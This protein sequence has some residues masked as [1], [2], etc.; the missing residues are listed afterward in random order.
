[1]RL[2]HTVLPEYMYLSIDFCAS[3]MLYA[4][5]CIFS[6][7]AKCLSSCITLHVAI[8]K[9]PPLPNPPTIT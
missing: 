7:P 2:L 6:H 4:V 5:A 3:S 1:M 9:L 8:L